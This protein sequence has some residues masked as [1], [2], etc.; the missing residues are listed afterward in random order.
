VQTPPGDGVLAARASDEL[1][2]KLDELIV[3]AVSGKRK[4]AA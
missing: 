3:G 1:F 4:R 2:R